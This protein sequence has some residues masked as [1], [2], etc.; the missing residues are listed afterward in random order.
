[1]RALTARGRVIFALA[2]W[3]ALALPA[4]AG[5]SQTI[6]FDA[7]PNQ[8]LGVSPF[9]IVAPA[10]SGLPVT[11]TS[12]LPAVCKTSGTMVM[13]LSVGTCSITAGQ[14]G[15]GSFNAATPVTRMFTVTEAKT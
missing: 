2:L 9:P 7:I 13:L 3:G 11:F 14:G 15:N 5:S 6:A 12:N 8:I 1:M 10:S 4:L